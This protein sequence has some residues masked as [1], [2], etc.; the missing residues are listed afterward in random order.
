MGQLGDSARLLSAKVSEAR[1]ARA[2]LVTA[3]AGLGQDMRL[4]EIGL[5]IDRGRCMGARGGFPGNLQCQAKGRCA[6][7]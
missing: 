1:E 5:S 2:K 7:R 3:R 4:K 6:R